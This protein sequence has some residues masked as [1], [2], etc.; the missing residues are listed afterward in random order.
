LKK[1]PDKANYKYLSK[2]IKALKKLN[3]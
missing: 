1:N 3:K 2:C